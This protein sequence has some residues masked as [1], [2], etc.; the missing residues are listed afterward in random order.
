[1]QAETDSAEAD[2]EG[3]GGFGMA[4]EATRTVTKCCYSLRAYIVV[5][6]VVRVMRSMKT[7]QLRSGRR[8]QA[9]KAWPQKQHPIRTKCA[10]DEKPLSLPPLPVQMTAVA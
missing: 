2:G 7:R 9:G 1:M 5:V 8:A 3:E 6:V 10:V 4:E